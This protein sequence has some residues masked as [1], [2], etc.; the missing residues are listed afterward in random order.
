[1]GSVQSEILQVLLKS[2][3]DGN[4]LSKTT[5]EAANQLVQ[6]TIDLPPFF[7]YPVCCLEEGEENGCTQG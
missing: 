4:V 2:L 3:Y 7:G 5:Y 6:S 1:M